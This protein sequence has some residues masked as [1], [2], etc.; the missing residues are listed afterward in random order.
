MAGQRTVAGGAQHAR[1][2]GIDGEPAELLERPRGGLDRA[3]DLPGADRGT[4][5]GEQTCIVIPE[6]EDRAGR[7]VLDRGI[8][9]HPVDLPCV[10]LANEMLPDSDAQAQGRRRGRRAPEPTAAAGIAAHEVVVIDALDHRGN[11]RRAFSPD[12][13]DSVPD[14]RLIDLKRAVAGALAPASSAVL[15]D[16][17]TGGG[18]CLVEGH[19]P[20]PV[21]LIWTLDATGYTGD[22][23]ERASRILPGWSVEKAAQ[24]G[25]A[26]IKLLVYYHPDSPTA[27][28]QEALVEHGVDADR[29][30]VVPDEEQAVDA[31]LRLGQPGDLVVLF[32]DALR[33]TWNQIVNFQSGGEAE[34]LHSDTAPPAVPVQLPELPEYVYDTGQSIVRDERGVRLAREQED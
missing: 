22:P 7:D 32:G 16:P 9:Q 3:L 20:G 5:P 13:P 26:G 21:G 34:V 10:R 24:L 17:E 30:E 8:P 23:H 1:E 12:D 27:R 18:Q 6:V 14:E 19:I 28:G 15:I 33:R 2:A 4:Q 31:A 25:A 11:L 29:I